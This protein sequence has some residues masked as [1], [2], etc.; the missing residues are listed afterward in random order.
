MSFPILRL[1]FVA[2]KVVLDHLN[3]VELVTVSLLSKRGDW[4]LKASGKKNVTFFDLPESE[5][6]DLR[7]IEILDLFLLECRRQEELPE[8]DFEFYCSVRSQLQL[9][10][11]CRNFLVPIYFEVL[12]DV[13]SWALEKKL[14][15]IRRNL[16]IGES[17]VPAVT[18]NVYGV[19]RIR[20][21]W[22][23]KTDGMIVFLDYFKNKFNL[24]IEELG[25]AGKDTRIIKTL[26]DHINSTQKVVRKVNCFPSLSVDEFKF[27]L[28]NVSST[29]NLSS[30]M[31]LSHDFKFN[32]KIRSKNL[33]I[34]NGHWFSLKNILESENEVIYVNG[35]NYTKEELK[36]FLKEW[37]AGK[38][39][40]LKE[41]VLATRMSAWDV[42]EGYERW[43]GRCRECENW[44]R[45]VITIKG[46]GDCHGGVHTSE[47]DGFHFSIHDN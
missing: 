21:F 45:N 25:F 43:E 9:S 8:W 16:K 2:L 32:G 13:D 3:N 26:V 24:P 46:H 28:E 30:L 27:I 38:L 6:R 35:S 15:R 22:N 11:S 41:V 44:P 34:E 18:N 42:I 5:I 12:G 10:I 14:G 40:K 23:R 17:I 1:P 19:E 20:T 7:N 37:K 31:E 47:D 36:T 33:D 4:F 39:P 29:E